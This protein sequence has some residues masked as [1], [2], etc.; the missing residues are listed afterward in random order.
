MPVN[1]TV[2]EVHI[3]KSYY[4]GKVTFHAYNSLNPLNCPASGFSSLW[5]IQFLIPHCVSTS[6]LLLADHGNMMICAIKNTH[7]FL[8]SQDPLHIP[9][10]ISILHNSQYT[11]K[12]V[13]PHNVQ[14]ANFE[15]EDFKLEKLAVQKYLASSG[16]S[17]LFS[18]P[19]AF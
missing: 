9:G 13:F 11:V 8:C 19:L 5:V 6:Q 4:F 15:R 3:R 18:V 7:S 17:E 16:M 10:T 1:H 2:I 12:C 14:F